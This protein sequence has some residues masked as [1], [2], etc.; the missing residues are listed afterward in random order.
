M[1]VEIE[2]TAQFRELARKLKAAGATGKGIR[3]EM[4]KG[5]REGAKP[6][7]EAAQANVRGL[8]I[9]GLPVTSR[10]K[11]VR[12]GRGG[13][14]ARAARAAARLGNRKFGDRGKVRAHRGAGLRDTVARTVS[15]K[16]S[17]AARG[18]SLRVLSVGSKMPRDQQSLPRLMNDGKIR[19]PVF[20]NRDVWA[21]QR[22]RPGWFDRAGRAKG[23]QARD[24]AAGTVQSYL[25]KLT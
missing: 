6:I 9:T 10:S 25:D 7:V 16:T 4:V 15:A 17:A 11:P 8:D 20:G 5:L 2:G 13:A 22:M 1:R 14:S 12:G 3:K 23:Q 18:A 21:E 24:K 19:H